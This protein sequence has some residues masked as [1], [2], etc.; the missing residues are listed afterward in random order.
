MIRFTHIYVEQ[1]T[2]GYPLAQKI[3]DNFPRAE[4]IAIDHYGEIFQRSDQSFRAQ[5][6]NVSLIL[7]VKRTGLLYSGSIEC[8]DYCNPNFYYTTPIINCIYDCSYCFLQG[9][10]S[11]AN[12]VVFVNQEDLREA[13]RAEIPQRKD[14]DNPLFLAISYDTDLPAID[15]RIPVVRDWLDFAGSQSNLIIELRTKSASITALR[16]LPITK[17]ILPAWTVSPQEVIDQY[18]SLTPALDKRLKAIKQVQEMG[19]PVRIC[20]DPVLP[21]T[22]WEKIYS[23]LVDQIFKILNADRIFDINVGIFRM[24]ATYYKRVKKMHPR[25]SLY[26]LETGNAVI[27]YDRDQV[28]ELVETV[29]R[30]IDLHLPPE[31][32]KIRQS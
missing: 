13:V 5:K 22:N 25:I 4:R 24:N 10:Y 1:A 28:S 29:K 30:M 26:S 18:E 31:R 21:I 20:I 11:S 15:Q 9:K 3:M 14:P 6:Q 23:R 2:D 17:Q 19:W 16:D 8:Q 32:I 7:A 12:L 27:S